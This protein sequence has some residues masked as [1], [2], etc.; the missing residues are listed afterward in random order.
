[1]S[2]SSKAVIGVLS[3]LPIVLLI[4]LFVMFLTIF[5]RML[6]WQNYD[7]T[8]QEMFS[9]FG[10]IFILGI[11]IGLLSF[12]LLVFFIMHL[13]RNKALDGIERVIWILV[14]LFAGLVGYPVYWYMRVWNDEHGPL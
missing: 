6:E 13:V 11:V 12:G 3:F 8:A 9:V 1:M 7:P 4:L 10:P 14:F 2:R 5:P